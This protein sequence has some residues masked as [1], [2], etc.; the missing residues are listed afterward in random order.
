M[1]FIRLALLDQRHPARKH[2]IHPQLDS[3]ISPDFIVDLS[4]RLTIFYDAGD[5]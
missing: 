3:K 5:I 1:S 2:R 4:N